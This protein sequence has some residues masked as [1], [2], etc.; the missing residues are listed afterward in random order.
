M[1]RVSHGLSYGSF[2]LAGL[3]LDEKEA[4]L[5]PAGVEPGGQGPSLPV[6]SPIDC[7]R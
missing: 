7:E 3:L 4:F 2:S 1:T 6:G 5:P